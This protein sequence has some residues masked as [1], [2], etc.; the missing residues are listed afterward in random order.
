MNL[1]KYHSAPSSLDHHDFATSNIL[2]VA[3]DTAS[4]NLKELK[5]KEDLWATD[6]EYAYRY[7]VAGSKRFKAGEK[8]ILKD[9]TYARMYASNVIGG[10]WPEGEDIIAKDGQQSFW[11]A[12]EVLGKRF[13]KG[14]PAIR[15]FES[16]WLNYCHR[17][18]IKE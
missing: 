10:P 18:D 13:I 5:K 1:Y 12:Y 11:Y 8:A 4:H 7:S 14:E 6:A 15:R 16:M 17:F 2:H 3:W 9:P